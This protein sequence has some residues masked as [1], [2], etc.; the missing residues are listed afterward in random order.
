MTAV[1]EVALAGLGTALATG[2][3]ALPVGREG[4]RAEAWRPALLGSAAAA[5]AVVSVLGLIAPAL[6]AGS[7]ATVAAGVASGAL[8][9]AVARRGLRLHEHRAGLLMTARGRR[10][11]LVMLVL[12]V[13]S[14]PEGFAIGSAWASGTAGLGV[15]VLVAIAV[16][17]IPEGTVT[18][19]PLA[20][21]G[22]GRAGQV[23]AA[24]GTSL[25]Q[26]V[27]AVLA[28]LLV[29]EIRALL[30]FSF[31]FAAG[32]ML[33]LVA[34][35]VAP[36]AWRPG[37]RR[38]GD[39]RRA[40]R[41]AG[42]WSP[43]AWCCR[44]PELH[45]R[46]Q[47]RDADGEQCDRECLHG[48]PGATAAVP[49]HHH[50]VARDPGHE[51]QQR[52]QRE[53]VERLGEDEHR[54]ER[55]ARDQHD[56]RA[57][58]D[59][60]GGPIE[61]ASLAEGVVERRLPAERLGDRVAGELAS[62]LFAVGLVGAAMLAASVLPLSTALGSSGEERERGAGRDLHGTPFTRGERAATLPSEPRRLCL[63]AVGSRSPARRSRP[64]PD[65]HA[66]ARSSSAV[67]ST[68]SNPTP[69]TVI[70]AAVYMVRSFGQLTTK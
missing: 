40:R 69:P 60:D 30:P 25:P 63:Q 18:A 65:R 22:V 45:E 29:E 31:G 33:A 2:L 66:R 14:L 26:P 55:D 54:H 1:A 41:A 5:M 70:A 21:A 6:D 43:S 39:R 47:D 16:Q 36:D 37:G 51:H 49:A 19:I 11:A 59:G 53:G 57:D 44:F 50:R 67:S 48:H 8:F 42:S 56:A 15:F 62:A 9:L 28:Y 68:T 38:A 23:A 3:G 34:V 61:H 46:D 64:R 4:A 20:I 24:V 10:A 52:Q 12:F 17:N 35:D 58:G 32:A 13:H 27:G 7:A